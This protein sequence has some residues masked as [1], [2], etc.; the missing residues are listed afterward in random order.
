MIRRLSERIRRKRKWMRLQRRGLSTYPSDYLDWLSFANAGMLHPGHRYLMSVAVRELPS[1]D[2]VLE[3]GSFCGLSTNV[4]TYFLRKYERRN[5]LI[6]TDPWM[7]EGEQGVTVPES[8]I[9]FVAYR[10]LV[11]SQFERNVRF[12]SGDRLPQA[13]PLSSD[14]FFAAWKRGGKHTDIFGREVELGGPV[15]LAYIDGDHEYE[16]VRR[17]FVN[18]DRFLVSGGLILF[19]DSDEFGAFPQIFQVV[20]EAI[21]GHGYEQVAENPHHLLRKSR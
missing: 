6:C 17:D 11:R 3:I 15:A 2:P 18:V 13:F 7:F 9:P 20:R 5:P 14:D 19:D 1:D 12:W 4:L 21:E 16:Q 10:D 8:E